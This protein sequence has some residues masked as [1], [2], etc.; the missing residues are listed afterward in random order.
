MDQSVRGAAFL[1]DFP[2]LRRKKGNAGLE[3][4]ENAIVDLGGSMRLG[5][6]KDMAW[7]PVSERVIFLKALKKAFGWTDA[8]VFDMGKSAPRVPST[9]KFFLKYIV[10]P[11]MA[12]KSSADYWSH[13]FSFG[14]FVPVEYTE[15]GSKNAGRLVMEIRDFDVDPIMCVQ[16][17]GYFLGVGVMTKMV[18]PTI[19]ETKCVHHGGPHHEFLMEWK[20][21]A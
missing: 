11:H 6:V 2:Y 15:D 8:N 10:S 7:Y 21:K 13:Y 17:S 16:L 12:F 3:S 19:R 18:D 5:D 4:L 1:E 14:T 9:M 20:I